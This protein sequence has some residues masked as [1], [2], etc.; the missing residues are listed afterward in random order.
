MKKIIYLFILIILIFPSYLSAN[1][2]KV[3]DNDIF[4]YLIFVI[5]AVIVII[6]F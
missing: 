6:K 3:I 1:S 4:I 5:F 2:I